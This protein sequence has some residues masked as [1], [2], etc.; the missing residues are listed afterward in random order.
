MKRIWIFLLA[1]SFSVC[2]LAQ[3]DDIY[4]S[5]SYTKSTKKTS[6]SSTTTSSGSSR[7][8]DE[9]NRVGTSSTSTNTEEISLGEDYQY[10]K[11]I[12][13]Y[14]DPDVV[15]IE[16]AEYVYIYNNNEEA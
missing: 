6:T 5:G 1:I 4:D 11:E 13:K 9:Y 7:S 10:T 2:A 12:A 8:I 14:Y 15:T 3:Y 16:D